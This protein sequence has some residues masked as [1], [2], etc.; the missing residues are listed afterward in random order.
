MWYKGG[1]TTLTPL[2]SPKERETGGGHPGAEKRKEKGS[3]DPEGEKI[4][5]GGP[6][7]RKSGGRKENTTGFHPPRLQRRKE[8]RPLF[9]P[10]PKRGRMIARERKRKG[11]GE[12][13]VMDCSSPLVTE[14]EEKG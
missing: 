3:G 12:G 9:P 14:K 13:G 11:R 1:G 10:P 7:A 2:R 8:G 6:G 5:P 4:L